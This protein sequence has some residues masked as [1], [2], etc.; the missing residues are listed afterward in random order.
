MKQPDYIGYIN[1]RQKHWLFTWS[2][3]LMQSA[4]CGVPL[5]LSLILG[6]YFSSLGLGPGAWASWGW[7]TLESFY[8]EERLSPGGGGHSLS[9]AKQGTYVPSVRLSVRLSVH[10]SFVKKIAKEMARFRTPRWHTHVRKS[11]KGPAPG[12]SLSTAKQGENALDS[13]CPST[14][15]SVKALMLKPYTW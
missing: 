11:G 15:L 2:G 7:K 6:K 5:Y 8:I 3:C 9:T 13:V 10:L 4:V 12:G 1:G 14:C